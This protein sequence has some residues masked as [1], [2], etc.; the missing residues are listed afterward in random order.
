MNALIDSP[1][2]RTGRRRS[3]TMAVLSLVSG[4]MHLAG[5]LMFFLVVSLGDD[6][7]GSDLPHVAPYTSVEFLA[8]VGMQ[9]VAGLILLSAVYLSFTSFRATMIA[10]GSAVALDVLFLLVETV[11]IDSGTS[12]LAD[13]GEVLGI[14]IVLIPWLG[15]PLLLTGLAFDAIRHRLTLGRMAVGTGESDAPGSRKRLALAMMLG[16]VLGLAFTPV[17]PLAGFVLALLAI[18]IPTY[19]R[20]AHWVVAPFL[21]LATLRFM[22]VLVTG[23]ADSFPGALFALGLTSLMLWLVRKGQ[24]RS[25][26][27]HHDHGYSTALPG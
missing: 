27:S 9:L 18:A 10:G 19:P 2:A 1:Q 3:A 23:P 8:L 6:P 13:T 24:A 17:N 11:A 4:L 16:M 26:T 21:V 12:I 7:Y 22:I 14:L 15:P 20:Y 25:G 5:S